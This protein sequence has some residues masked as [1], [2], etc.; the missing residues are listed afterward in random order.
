MRLFRINKKKLDATREVLVGEIN[1]GGVSWIFEI[2][3]FIAK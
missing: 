2:D 1:Q 3:V